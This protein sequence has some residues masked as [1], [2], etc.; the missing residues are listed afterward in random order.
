[1]SGRSSGLIL[2]RGRQPSQVMSVLERHFSTWDFARHSGSR[3]RL[4]A[5]YPRER[6]E[7]VSLSSESWTGVYVEHLTDLFDLSYALSK[8]WP[9]TAV[10]A[11]RAYLHGHWECKAYYD[12]DVLFNIGDAPDHELPWVGRPMDS[13]SVPRVMQLL[14]GDEWHAFLERSLDSTATPQCLGD[15]VAINPTMAFE[16]ALVLPSGTSFAWFRA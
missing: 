2:V 5:R 15:V 13:E 11:S 12:R 6:R 1:M 3:E 9:N 7:F 10:I 4:I 16:D 8:R 14:G